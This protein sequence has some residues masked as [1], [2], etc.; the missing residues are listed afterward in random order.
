M[1]CTWYVK[2][3]EEKTNF[4]KYE[5]IIIYL[6]NAILN[7]SFFM[8]MSNFNKGSVFKVIIIIYNYS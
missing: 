8:K 6:R 4:K 7:K 5:L 3:F 2:E 1:K